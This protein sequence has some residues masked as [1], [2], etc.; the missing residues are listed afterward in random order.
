MG[1]DSIR[2]RLMSRSAKTLSAL[3]SAPGTFFSAKAMDVLF[4]PRTILRDLPISRKR[5]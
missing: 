1:R 3:K 4:A 2:L 5:V